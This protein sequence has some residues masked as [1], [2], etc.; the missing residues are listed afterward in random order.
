MSK[1][2]GTSFFSVLTAKKKPTSKP[3]ESTDKK[4]G[5]GFFSVL[6]GGKSRQN[7][8]LA[9]QNRDKGNL[10]ES[11]IKKSKKTDNKKELKTTASVKKSRTTSPFNRQ[12][13]KN[14]YSDFVKNSNEIERLID[15]KKN[16]ILLGECEEISYEE[17]D[18][19][20]EYKERSERFVKALYQDNA[21]LISIASM[22]RDF[23]AIPTYSEYLKLLKVSSDRVGQIESEDESRYQ[24]DRKVDFKKG[25]KKGDTIQAKLFEYKYGQEGFIGGVGFKKQYINQ[26]TLKAMES[27]KLNPVYQD[28]NR[29]IE[30]CIDKINYV[31]AKNKPEDVAIFNIH[32]FQ[33]SLPERE[34]PS[35]LFTED[36]HVRNAE[37]LDN[38]REVY[39]QHAVTA[40]RSGSHIRYAYCGDFKDPNKVQASTKISN[41]DY[42]NYLWSFPRYKSITTD[43]RIDYLR[44]K[45]RIKIR[46]SLHET[47]ETKY[48]YLIPRKQQEEHTYVVG[49]SGSG[50]SELLKYLF[51]QEVLKADRSSIFLDPHGDLCEELID[52]AFLYPD[53]IKNIIYIDTDIKAI[54]GEDKN[55]LPCINPLEINKKYVNSREKVESVAYLLALALEQITNTESSVNM[56][57][58]LIPCLCVLL[59]KDDTTLY[60]LSRFMDDERNSDLV[61]IGERSENPSHANYFKSIFLTK[62]TKSTKE[63]LS[64]RLQVALN[65]ML[66]S[67]MT[68]GKTTIDLHEIMREGNKYIIFRLEKESTKAIQRELGILILTTVLGAG[69]SISKD[70]RIGTHIFLDEFQN[71]TYSDIE[72]MLSECRKYRLYLTMAHQFLDQIRDTIVKKS[73]MVNTGMKL[74]GLTSGN[75]VSYMNNNGEDRLKQENVDKGGKGKFQVRVKADGPSYH[76]LQ[77]PGTIVKDRVKPIAISKKKAFLAQ[78]Y[79]QYYANSLP[80]QESEISEAIEEEFTTGSTEVPT[81]VIQKTK[82][83]NYDI[84]E[85]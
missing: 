56:R 57:A 42:W 41:V 82:K 4:S 85:F 24:D 62:K 10:A 3:K 44:Q 79:E 23:K 63:A 31:G 14:F 61:K 7:P 26:N 72:E 84:E 5:G 51:I 39:A 78:Q 1:K 48:N 36:H 83:K 73:I 20:E 58:L 9:N 18:R 47:K 68:C 54:L 50:K 13:I 71:F 80:G 32:Y 16:L 49:S 6:G 34:L 37:W 25:I 52:L 67:K 21:E 28:Y 74:I 59:E 35:Y 12:V 30:W 29:F 55:N 81:A 27:L 15:P 40:V 65:S 38:N 22:G 19:E 70:K 43:K 53:Y 66:F 60:D 77:I 17:T 45:R 2:S 8:E 11:N 75:T 33:N 46:F 69:F 64:I 76:Y